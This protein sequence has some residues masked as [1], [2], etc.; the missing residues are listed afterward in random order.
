[1]FFRILV[2]VLLAVSFVVSK[3]NAAPLEEYRAQARTIL[4]D[5]FS[6]SDGRIVIKVHAAADRKFLGAERTF[7]I[8]RLEKKIVELT[9]IEEKQ[10]V[11]RFRIEDG[12]LQFDYRELNELNFRVCIESPLVPASTSGI[13]AIRE[14][15]FPEADIEALRRAL[16][17]QIDA[18]QDIDFL[19][20]SHGFSLRRMADD[21]TPRVSVRFT[22]N[23]KE[24]PKFSYNDKLFS[25]PEKKVIQVQEIS[26]VVPA[27]GKSVANWSRLVVLSATKAKP[28]LREQGIEL[29][30]VGKV[31]EVA[32][33]G[34]IVE[35]QVDLDGKV[36]RMVG[37]RGVK[38]SQ[39]PSNFIKGTRQAGAC[40]F[41]F[42]YDSGAKKNGCTVSETPSRG[43]VPL[44]TRQKRKLLPRS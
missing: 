17:S 10:C 40:E 16:V 18:S 41:V 27:F 6:V 25:P 26:G 8:T 35:I 4:G 36:Y 31:T 19:D 39:F 29:P 42:V 38:K 3:S 30:A 33:G 2:A 20:D 11:M 12:K 1:M 44:R 23:K 13:A 43:V 28:L 5:C 9:I 32:L 15:G 37:M 34:S 21:K 7:F 22:A 24:F 14:T